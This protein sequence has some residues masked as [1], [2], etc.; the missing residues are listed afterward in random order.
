MVH[1]VTFVIGSSI[2]G[3]LAL[4]VK[5]FT[6]EDII[7]N[8]HIIHLCFIVTIFKLKFFLWKNIGAGGAL[9]TP[10]MKHITIRNGEFP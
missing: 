3:N 6:V 4:W 10:F 8:V 5:K 2:Y 9:A 1:F 7:G